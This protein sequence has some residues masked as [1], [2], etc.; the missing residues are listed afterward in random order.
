MPALAKAGAGIHLFG[1]QLIMYKVELTNMLLAWLDP[2]GVWAL[3]SAMIRAG[4][5]VAPSRCVGFSFGRTEIADLPSLHIFQWEGIQWTA[6][7]WLSRFMWL[8]VAL[9]LLGVVCLRRKGGAVLASY[10]LGLVA[11]TLAKMEFA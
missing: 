2:L 8:G 4:L 10:C 3:V 1:E 9:G 7:I 6:D 11:L 5:E